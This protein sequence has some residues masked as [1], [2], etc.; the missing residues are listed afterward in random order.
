[1]SRIGFHRHSLSLKLGFIIIS[2]VVVL[3]VSLLG[4]LYIRSRQLVKQEAL[5]RAERALD[6]TALR[7]S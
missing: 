4:L 7:V 1:M 2:F 5:E 3:F 6:K